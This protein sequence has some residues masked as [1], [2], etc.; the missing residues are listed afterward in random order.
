[1]DEVGY[2]IGYFFGFICGNKIWVTFSVIIAI[3][4]IYRLIKSSKRK[5][6]VYNKFAL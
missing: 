1:M 3:Y 4:V 2:Q 6:P 5:N